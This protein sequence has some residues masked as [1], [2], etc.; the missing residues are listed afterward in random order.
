MTFFVLRADPDIY[1]ALVLADKRRWSVVGDLHG[2]SL[3]ASWKPVEVEVLRGKKRGDHPYLSPGVPVV[4]ERAWKV[5][6]PI[7]GGAVEALPLRAGDVRYLALNVTV[8]LDALDLTAS[9]VARFPSGGI[10][11]VRKFVLRPEVVKGHDIFKV[12]EA[13]LKYVLV[14]D[15]FKAAVEQHRLRG[16]VFADVG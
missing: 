13:E 7:V 8:V 3:A 11:S 14:S 10:M 9:E 12:R 6:K 4:N 5:L 1:D 2:Q 15:R 16:F